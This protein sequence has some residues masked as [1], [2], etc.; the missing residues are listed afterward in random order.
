MHRLK[1]ILKDQIEWYKN[2]KCLENHPDE[3][4]R[5]DDSFIYDMAIEEFSTLSRG[6]YME[7]L[8]ILSEEE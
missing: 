6:D 5:I 3:D 8:E 1:E 4:L 7:I 2:A